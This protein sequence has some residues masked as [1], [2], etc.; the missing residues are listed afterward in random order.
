MA[1]SRRC[2]VLAF[3]LAV[4]FGLLASCGDEDSPS[5]PPSN[6]GTIQGTLLAAGQPIHAHVLAVNYPQ[7][8]HDPG[9]IAYVQTSSDSSGAYSM[10]LPVGRYVLRMDGSSCRQFYGHGA[11]VDQSEA[12]TLEVGRGESVTANLT[13]GAARLEVATPSELEGYQFS[14]VLVSSNPP[15]CRVSSERGQ[16]SEGRAIIAFPRVDPGTYRMKL[17]IPTVGEI[18][19]PG[20]T[21]ASGADSIVVP[22][23]VEAHYQAN[24]SQPA[25]LRGTVTGSW[26]ELGQYPP[27]L[28]LLALAGR[29][30]IASTQANSV[31][32]SYEFLVYGSGQVLL[33]IEIGSVRRWYGGTTIDEAT[34]ID[35]ESGRTI[36]LNFRESG[37]AG[38]LN[39]EEPISGLTLWLQDADGTTRGVGSVDGPRGFFR[40]SNL[41]QG[42]Y[43]L[44]IQAG[45]TWIDQWYDKADSL[46]AATPIEVTREGQ[47]VWLDLDLEDGGRI[48]GRLR[49]NGGEPAF[50]VP[51]NLVSPT[52]NEVIRQGFSNDDGGGFRFLA[53]PDGD[54]RIVANPNEIETPVW[55]PGVTDPAQA[56]VVSI[57]NHTEV[58]GIFFDLP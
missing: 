53:L 50:G 43:F 3:S 44:K 1:V 23:G 54:Y 16:I 48:E 5:C 40:I 9:E 36:E 39:R 31:D 25:A 18:W 17:F 33:Q 29:E 2:S 14:A 10:E 6:M 49:R 51:V 11:L 42:T 32:G 8:P 35:L 27:H 22:M 38:W 26:Q 12:E 37:I 46:A 24:L 58:T 15:T 34:R 28:N 45:P 56:V 55:Y 4:L 21:D 30:T 57:R 13:L 41:L 7:D 52:S 19:L 20:A 47:V